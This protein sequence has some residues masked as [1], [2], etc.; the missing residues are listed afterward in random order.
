M[1]LVPR[2][3]PGLIGYSG[4]EKGTPENTSCKFSHLVES[5][6]NLSRLDNQVDGFHVSYVIQRIPVEHYE[7]GGLSGFDRSCRR[8][9]TQGQGAIACRGDQRVGVGHAGIFDEDT[10]LPLHKFFLVIIGSRTD[11]DARPIGL[12]SEPANNRR[13]PGA[14]LLSRLAS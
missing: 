5:I 1:G 8:F 4:R 6:E 10:H 11:S 14:A 2:T 13:M 7:V 9:Y 12:G 3:W